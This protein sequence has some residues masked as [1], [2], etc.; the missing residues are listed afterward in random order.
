MDAEI[1]AVGSEILLGQIVNTNATYLSQK[2]N[3]LGINVFYSSVVGDNRTRM[4]EAIKLA[5][6]RSDLV[7]LAGG[8]GPTA[9]DLTKEVLADFVNQS[10]VVDEAAKD[11]LVKYFQKTNRPLTPNNMQQAEYVASGIAINNPEGLAVGCFVQTKTCD[12]MIV[13]GPPR[14]LKAMFEQEI[15]P[16]LMKTYHS[17]RRIVS[18][19]LRFFG[20]GESLLVTKLADIIA[21]Q[22]NP[23]IAPYAKP[24]EVTLRITASEESE[25]KAWQLVKKMKRDVL[26][27]VGEFYYGS[28][29][30]NSLAQVVIKRLQAT[31]QKVTAAESLTA[32]LLQATLASIPHASAVF[33]GGFVTYANEQ[34]VKM[35]NVSEATIA[36][37]TV[38]SKSVAK[39][40][41]NGAKQ[42]VNADFAVSLTG[43]A[44]PDALEGH[45]AG[46]VYIGIASPQTTKAYLYHFAG[47]RN[48]IREMAVYAALWQLLKALDEQ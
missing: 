18:E 19:T 29:D 45:P 3:Q 5:A 8:T 46:T 26:A 24:C 43:A 40:M 22:T 17:K 23:T 9:D 25:A 32:G 37:D 12:F 7:I 27:R 2:L 33:D 1:I 16:L 41:A 21:N 28:G 34:K 36:Q 10:L 20:I 38:V 47:S 4:N 39:Q 31:K 15:Y 44:G 48:F 11:Y 30:D 42:K 35:L 13:P 14:E 6:S